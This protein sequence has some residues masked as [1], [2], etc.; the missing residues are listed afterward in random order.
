MSSSPAAA[1]AIPVTAAAPSLAPRPD[2]DGLLPAGAHFTDAEL[3]TLAHAGAV[4]RLLPGVYCRAGRGALPQTRAAALWLLAGP[5]L[6]AGWTAVGPSAAWV[7][8]GGPAPQRL[9]AA[10][11]HYH[12]LPSGGC[13]LPWALVQSDVAAGPSGVAPAEEDVVRVGPLRVT[14]AARTVEDLLLTAD[15]D[16]AR[17]AAHLMACH[18][19]Q[20]LT[21]RLARPTRR[22]GVVAARA[23]LAAL[24]AA[25][26]PRA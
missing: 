6:A 20:G 2:D 7:L 1:P 17:R 21:E 12:R 10:V 8:A 4:E 3:Q 24:L 5:M 13:A 15:P 9:H 22:A 16:H 11:G 18:G 23:R 19:T 26:E 14:T 25:L